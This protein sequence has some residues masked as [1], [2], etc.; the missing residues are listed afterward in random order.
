MVEVHIDTF[1]VRWGIRSD[2]E[3]LVAGEDRNDVSVI[4]VVD[5]KVRVKKL[6]GRE[7]LLVRKR[8]SEMCGQWWGSQ[9]V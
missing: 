3:I 9:M 4:A 2:G 7:L 5:G 8:V 6:R 1:L